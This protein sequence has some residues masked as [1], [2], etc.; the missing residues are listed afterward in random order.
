MSLPQEP[1]TFAAPTARNM[2]A[3]GKREAR[4]PWEGPIQC[5]SPERAKFERRYFGLSG[6]NRVWFA[7]PGATRFALAPGFHISRRWRSMV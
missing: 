5:S 4:R 3:R 6:L 1:R 2:T 7:N